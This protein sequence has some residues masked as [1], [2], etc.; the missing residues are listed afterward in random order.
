MSEESLND[1][2]AP[3]IK[4]SQELLR[5]MIDNAPISDE[6]RNKIVEQLPMIA[7]NLDDATRR[8]YDPQKIWFESIQYADYVDQLAEHLRDAVMDDHSDD[9]K[10]EIAVGLHTMSGIWKAM[11]E[12]AMTI[13][14]DMKIKSEMYDFDE[15]IIGIKEKDA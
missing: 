15:V 12:N 9:C 5:Q 6:M 14:D 7:E 1:K 8:I 13:L 2:F 10:M 11:A 4:V 3:K